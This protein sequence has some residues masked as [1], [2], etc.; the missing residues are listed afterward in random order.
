[1]NRPWPARN[2]PL[3]E[4]ETCA[5]CSRCTKD[6]SILID[7]ARSEALAPKS[8]IWPDP[9]CSKQSSPST[10]TLT[11]GAKRRSPAT[12]QWHVNPATADTPATGDSPAKDAAWVL[13]SRKEP[14]PVRADAGSA[15]GPHTKLSD[16]RNSHELVLEFHA[17]CWRKSA[18]WGFTSTGLALVKDSNSAMERRDTQSDKPRLRQRNAMLLRP[19]MDV[20][21]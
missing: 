3:K 10:A 9:M 20:Q 6:A 19:A 8:T 21:Q 15:R 12:S 17:Q 4:L 5:C 1:V 18:Q 11:P 7:D 13:P 2:A 14:E 16:W